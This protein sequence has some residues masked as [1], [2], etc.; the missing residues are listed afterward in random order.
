[1]K[2]TY[3]LAI[4]EFADVNWTTF[5]SSVRA[6][7]ANSW[8]CWG[9]EGSSSTFPVCRRTS[10]LFCFITKQVASWR[11]WGQGLVW[12]ATV[13][14]APVLHTVKLPT[15]AASHWRKKQG[16]ARRSWSYESRP[17][18]SS[19]SWNQRACRKRTNDAVPSGHSSKLSRPRWN[20]SVQKKRLAKWQNQLTFGIT[21]A[22]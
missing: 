17:L 18:A 11:G 8:K 22:T 2:L 16:R 1:M 3:D 20:C 13:H 4:V 9:S 5:S 7:R 14:W 15:S 6:L 19:R 12:V 21:S 10:S